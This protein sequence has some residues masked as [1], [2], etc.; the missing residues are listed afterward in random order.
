M[1]DHFLHDDSTE[2]RLTHE[3]PD[4]W[5]R[6]RSDLE[7]AALGYAQDAYHGLKTSI[8]FD[9]FVRRARALAER[10]RGEA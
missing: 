1:L 9:G 10:E 8:D 7:S 6:W 5:E 2:M 4:S 3:R